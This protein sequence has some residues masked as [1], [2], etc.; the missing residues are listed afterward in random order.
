[1]IM[2]AT[3]F[4]LLVSTVTASVLAAEFPAGVDSRDEL[5]EIGCL[6]VTK[7]PYLADPTGRADSTEAIQRAAGD[8]RD[9]GLVCFFPEGSYVISDTISCQQ[10]V[11]KLDVPR[12]VDG[13][14]EHY[15]PVRRPMILMGSTKGQRP[16][17]RLSKEAQGFDDPSKPK[18]AV[19]I[20]AQT[21]FDAPGKEE[22]VW[23]K[24]QANISFN[25]VFKGIDIDVRGHAGA[26]G[27]RHSGSQG[28][29]LQDVT[30]HA[31]GAYAGMNN[32]CGQGGGTYNVEVLGGQY[33][34]VIEPDSRFPI[35]VACRFQGQ[36]KAA[37]RYA[38][39]GSQ[40]PTLLVGCRLEPAGEAV[41]DFTTERSYAGISM[42]DCVVSMKP[43]G[44][45]CKTRKDENVFLEETY[46]RGAASVS[47]RG[48]KIPEPQQW[49]RIERYSSHTDQ[50][51]N[52]VDGVQGSG[53]I[54]VWKTAVSEPAFETIRRRHYRGTPSF[55][56]EDAVNVKS[57]GAAGDGT[58]DD[59]GA[60]EKAIA[61]HDRIFIP[62]GDYRISGTL[63]LR[64][65]TH[66]FGLSR[67]LCSIGVTGS[68]RSRRPRGGSEPF[69]VITVDDADA[70]PGLSF[71]SVR[72]RVEW[73]SG[74]G[75]WM[76][77]SGSLAVSGHAGGRLYGVMA[78]GRPLV[79]RG[80]RQPTSFYALN[81][82][83]VV[84]NP[85][86][87]IRDCSGVRV[88]YFKV[89]SGTIQR[90]N[91]GDANT[92]CRISDS[93][94]V[95]VYCMY[96]N[97]LKLVGRPMLEIVNSQDLV[98]AQLKAFRS[99]DFPHVT[100]TCGEATIEVP[101]TKMCA[102]FVRD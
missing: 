63:R 97:V 96:G 51:V 34:I 31:E 62:K 20:W 98:V 95:R 53:E 44:V 1:M 9:H 60:F 35:L 89:E 79:L 27:I 72:G 46:A 36:S 90:P 45:I 71:L 70:A 32:C 78:M 49:T 87:E 39:G 11:S 6:D 16:V 59:T 58:T 26:I 8:A 68:E 22:P 19:W 102:L 101:S 33:G 5:L 13:G 91:A 69:S 18:I 23:G 82:E 77:A 76:L 92:P 30:I 94:D 99:G 4:C 48:S 54:A 37:I 15:W 55:E 56:D 42:V 88:Y 10:Q 73:R 83:R 25:H 43:G 28:S 21:W 84:T 24:E 61:A 81:V 41:V 93:R 100:E 64:P 75:T 7:A 29:T 40:V 80:I 47:S 57:F 50:G 12:H 17:L 85:Q 52:L 66:L 74:Q 2:K 65:K 14:T 86:S 67:T 38:R 3:V